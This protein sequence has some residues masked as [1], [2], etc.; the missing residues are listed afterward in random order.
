M[1]EEASEWN[2]TTPGSAFYFASSS[3]VRDCLQNT[4]ETGTNPD[5]G[6]GFFG[7]IGY[8]DSFEAT[9]SPAYVTPA[10][11]PAITKAHVVNINGYRGVD[12][13]VA[14]PV[15]A[16]ARPKVFQAL[17]CGKSEFWVN[18]EGYVKAGGTGDATRDA[19]IGRMMSDAQNTSVIENLPAN[20]AF[21]ATPNLLATKTTDRI[22]PDHLSYAS[23]SAAYDAQC[24][25]FVA[26]PA[27]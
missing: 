4:A 16:T 12:V 8:I 7:K 18:L 10:V 19:F 21:E 24:R 3:G 22:S 23:N 26:S 25:G 11:A 27:P 20:W 5:T 17:R 6:D 15:K 9:G 1:K 2:L 14:D 13:T